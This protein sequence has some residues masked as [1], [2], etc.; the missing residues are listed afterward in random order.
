MS[1]S[2]IRHIRVLLQPLPRSNDICIEFPLETV[3]C[4]AAYLDLKGLPIVSLELNV[5]KEATKV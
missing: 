2:E 5:L 3:T 4:I 1:A